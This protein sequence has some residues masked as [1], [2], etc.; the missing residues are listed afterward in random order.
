[1]K[2]EDQVLVLVGNDK[3]GRAFLA[4]ESQNYSV[5][6]AI[7]AGSHSP[8]RVLSLLRKG[9]LSLSVVI[10]MTW[11][12]MIR[13]YHKI[14]SL[15]KVQTNSDLLR[16]IEEDQIN[17][18][19]LYRVGLIIRRKVLQTGATVYNIHCARLPEYGGLMAL[20]RALDKKDY[21]QEATLHVV[22]EK[23]DDGETINTVPFLLDE[24]KSYKKNED[25]AFEAGENL[26]RTFL[27][28][29]KITKE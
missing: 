12:E 2:K 27:C 4:Q 17:Q 1:L 29:Y 24:K 8:K 28:P 10:K 18:V 9:S 22:N 6:F 21:Q 11:A 7:Y 14:P 23:V 3:R 19:V 16:L 20:Q 25:T 26:L 5:R 15:Q 13:P